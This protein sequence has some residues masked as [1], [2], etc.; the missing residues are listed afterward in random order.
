MSAIAPFKALLA[1]LLL[2]SC[3]KASEITF[4]EETEAV[5]TIAYLKSLCTS[6]TTPI[7]QQIVVRGVVTANDHYG[8]FY[9]TLVI[10]DRS[11]GLSIALDHP[12]IS[13]DFPIGAAVSVQCNGLVLCDYGGKI[14]LGTTPDGIGG[15]GRIPRDRIGSYLRRNTSD[16]RPRQAVSRSFAEISECH[17]DTYI[18]FEGVHFATSDFWCDTDPETQQPITTERQL[19]DAAGHTFSVRTLATCIYAKE[20]VP[21]GTGS[22][23]G[24]VDY[25]NGHFSL[26]VTQRK[27]IF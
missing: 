24:I 4:D 5:R 21:Q 27:I 22:I 7:S 23:Y 17:V 25:F 20:P 15:A 16:D 3:D 8:E 12:L 10:E 11:G 14:Q 9:K 1:V 13:D 19:V 6:E 2:V 26:R 18:R